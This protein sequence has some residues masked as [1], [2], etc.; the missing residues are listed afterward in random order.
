[1][2]NYLAR[3]NSNDIEQNPT[4][5]L[6]R[7]GQLLWH[8]PRAFTTHDKFSGWKQKQQ[9]PFHK[10][11]LHKPY[12]IK[13]GF[14]CNY[15]GYRLRSL[16][17]LRKEHRN[18]KSRALTHHNNSIRFCF[19]FILGNELIHYLLRKISKHKKPGPHIYSICSLTLKTTTST[20][21]FSGS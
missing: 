15:S 21:S 11:N 16:D 19:F 13:D 5:R 4:E 6:G 2:V 3:L 14:C 17:G 7:E 9:D 1:M 12:L 18:G 10:K 20:L 8:I